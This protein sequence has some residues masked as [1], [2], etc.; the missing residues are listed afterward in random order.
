MKWTVLPI[1]ALSF[2]LALM[3][4]GGGS[5]AAQDAAAPAPQPPLTAAQ[6]REDLAFLATQVRTRHPNPH[7]S[8]DSETFQQAVDDLHARIPGLQRN[9]VIV[10][11]MALAALVGD[12]HTNVSPL[13]DPAFGFRELPLKFYWFEDGL[14]VRAAR[15][16]HR[17]LIG[18]RIEAIGGVPVDEAIERVARIVSRDTPMGLRLYAPIF[19]AMPGIQHAL[20]LSSTADASVLTVR[21]DGTT[22][23]VTVEADGIPPEWPPDTDISLITLGG[24]VDGR[25]APDPQWLQAPLDYHRMVDIAEHDALYVRL[26]MVT[27]IQG[28]SLDQFGEAIL[29]RARETEPATL[30]L[31]LR[32]NRGGNQD[33]RYGFIADIIRATGAGTRLYVLTGRGTFSASQRIL[34][35]LATLGDAIVVG[36]PASSRPNS[37]GDS[38][39]DTLPHS[40]IALRTSTLWQQFDWRDVAWTPVD[41][42]VPLTYADYAS[43][44]DPA[45][46]IALTRGLPQDLDAKLQA[47][48]AR[49]GPDAVAPT[50]RAFLD[51]PQNRY[52]DAEGSLL[53]A[54]RPLLSAG[55]A[56]EAVA[57]AQVV[58]ERIPDSTRAWTLLAYAHE[59]A[60][61]G[62]RAR[63]AAEHV[64]RI[65]PNNR[66]VRRFVER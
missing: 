26:N 60:G 2:A 3:P 24:W 27:G 32:L 13:K 59:A 58:T 63:I 53:H 38:Y 43:G 36:E 45:L 40:R 14:Y 29:A 50:V 61:D 65:D 7:H 28:Q 41:I 39:R 11:F 23:T 10:G 52:A 17:D 51:N 57:A 49:D 9:E 34:D 42:G 55:K 62:A 5:H 1:V 18:A 25:T 19:L 37:Y 64:I 21:R 22:R 20:G 35:E 16:G 6:W 15:P 8:V 46:D 56:A 30:V 66:D 4:V 54:L 12:G 33:L 47:A 31:D 48:I 44:Q